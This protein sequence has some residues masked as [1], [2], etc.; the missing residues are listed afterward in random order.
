M[1][2][3]VKK[4]KK[5]LRY[6]GAWICTNLEYEICDC[7]ESLEG[8]FGAQSEEFVINEGVTRGQLCS[9]YM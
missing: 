1:K 3:M 5:V 9:K 6:T 7:A 4:K 2:W 8:Q